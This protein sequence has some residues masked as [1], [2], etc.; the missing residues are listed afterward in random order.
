[1]NAK[2]QEQQQAEERQKRLNDYHAFL[3]ASKAE[4]LKMIAWIFS[5]Q[6]KEGF[7]R[8]QVATP[9]MSYAH[10]GEPYGIVWTLKGYHGTLT[11][12][13][14]YYNSGDRITN[15]VAVE[16][17][18]YPIEVVDY[19]DYEPE[20]DTLAQKTALVA[21][22]ELLIADCPLPVEASWRKRDGTSRYLP[23]KLEPQ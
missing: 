17:S 12:R 16:A 15:K 13:H 10:D 19:D 5:L 1:M 21:H 4:E 3:A 2:T 8:N 18:L 20:E 11:F 22:A 9:K 23:N 7:S 14:R 6:F